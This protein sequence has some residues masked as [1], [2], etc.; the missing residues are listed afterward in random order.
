MRSRYLYLPL[1]SFLFLGANKACTNCSQLETAVKVLCAGG[2]PFTPE[3]QAAR[4]AWVESKCNVLPPTPQPTPDVPPNGGRICNI[5]EICGCWHKPP[6]EDWQYLG[7][8]PI[9]PVD[10]CTGITC[11][12]GFHCEAGKCVKD[13]VIPPS[14]TV[15]CLAGI[16]PLED[17]YINAKTSGPNYVDSTERCRNRA[18]CEKST[19]IVGNSNCALGIE[20]TEQRIVCE[21]EHSPGCLKWYY[22]DENS[23]WVRC[24]VEEHPLASCDHYDRY[25]DWKGAYTGNCET[26]PDGYPIAGNEMVPHGKTGFKACDTNM[27]VCSDPLE[28]DR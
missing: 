6:N 8:C 7:D 24:G 10:S 27:Q 3:C 19:G 28:L 14:P 18:Y 12:P 21:L 1:I 13:P 2:E 9:P 26:R 11:D 4:D 20:G 17:R 25:I 15:K 22:R 23:N 16:C 5:D